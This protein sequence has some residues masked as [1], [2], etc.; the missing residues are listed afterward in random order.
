LTTHPSPA[1]LSALYR[2]ECKRL[3]YSPDP[4]Q[5]H[6]VA[7]LDDLRA[8]LLV[9]A[10][11]T[12]LLQGLLSRRRDQPPQRG[13]YIW[14]GV[15]RGK[16]WLMDLFFQS[17]P[18]K[19]KQR[20]HFHRFMQFVHDELRKHKDAANPLELIADKAA[21]R[22]RVLCFDELFVADIADAMLLGTLFRALFDRG[23]TL[24]AT[25]NIPPDDLYKG[26]LQHARFLPAIRLLKQHTE[27]VHMAHG[28]DYRLRML[29]RA[30]IWF[31]TSSPDH[32]HALE[33]LFV[34]LAGESGSSTTT[35]TINHR[36]LHAYR[37]SQDVVWFS[38]KE[39]C[40]GPRG[41]AD[42]IE[43]ARCYHTVFLSEVPVLGLEL[44]NQARRFISLVDEFYDRA[45]KLVVSAA[46]PVDRLYRGSKLT[47]EFE[48]TKSRLTE[49]QSQ[50]YL[51]RQHKA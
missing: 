7:R 46:A 41:Q 3:G 38:F 28:A 40:D 25:S 13:L 50:Q 51:A 44:E 21:K 43:L 48:R 1:S 33:R 10:P 31:D 29:E 22:A 26:G 11:T 17:L 30:S 42:Y 35:L 23:V 6:V 24:V 4:V 27:V 49:M 47:F 15:G 8:R 37:H 9:P 34:D 20:S 12:G 16:T 32:Q 2:N 39:L 45:V 36:R 18:L 19:H 5:E 14:G